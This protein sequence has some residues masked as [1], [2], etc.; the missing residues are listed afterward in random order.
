MQAIRNK[1]TGLYYC[2][3]SPWGQ[4]WDKVNKPGHPPVH[5][6][7]GYFMTA[8]EYMHGVATDAKLSDDDLELV[9]Y[10]NGRL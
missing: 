1:K 3:T 5:A 7:D 4:H 2:G 6:D 9:E 8:R 10:P